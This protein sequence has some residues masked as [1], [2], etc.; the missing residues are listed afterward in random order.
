[1]ER[2]GEVLLLLVLMTDFAVLVTDRLSTCIRIMA[3][4]GVLLGL[5]PFASGA[6]IGVHTVVLSLGTIAIKSIVLPRVLSWAIRE[7]E[8]RRELEPSIGPIGMVVLGLVAVGVAFG[9][10]TRLPHA[11]ATVLPG[12]VPVSLASLMMGFVVLTTRRKALSLVIGYLML[13]NGIYVFGLTLAGAIP[14][15]VEMGVLLDVLVGVFIMGLVVFQIHRQL[16]TQDSR[17]LTELRD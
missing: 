15:L 9:V 10:A 14:L 7:A 3:A 4:Q 13:E 2:T 6:A 1:M 12:L 17:R 8:V 16:E 11:G 5:L